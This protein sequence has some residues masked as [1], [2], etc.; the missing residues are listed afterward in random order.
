MNQESDLCEKHLVWIVPKK[1]TKT[2]KNSSISDCT[3]KKN[4]CNEKTKTMRLYKLF[5]EFKE[6]VAWWQMSHKHD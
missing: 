5:A 1:M 4:I 3:M 6:M 2:I